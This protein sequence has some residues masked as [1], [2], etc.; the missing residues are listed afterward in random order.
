MNPVNLALHYGYRSCTPQDTGFAVRP[1]SLMNVVPSSFSG[2]RAVDSAARLEMMDPI[3]TTASWSSY[4]DTYQ[5]RAFPT[6][7]WIDCQEME[8]SRGI[9][10][11]RCMHVV[12]TQ[13]ANS[14]HHHL[15]GR[16]R[17]T[18]VANYN[19]NFLPPVQDHGKEHLMGLGSGRIKLGQACGPACCL[20]SFSRQ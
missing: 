2:N 10:I 9:P 18:L 12:E 15:V 5:I 4:R 1:V 7:V 19:R 8:H 17:A 13:L 11:M 16:W 3:T 20:G 6:F 14:Q